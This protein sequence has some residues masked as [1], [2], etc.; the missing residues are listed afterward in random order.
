MLGLWPIHNFSHIPEGRSLY[1]LFLIREH[2]DA[3]R[4]KLLVRPMKSSFCSHASR[5]HSRTGN[6]F[7]SARSHRL[8]GDNEESN[9]HLA[10]KS[11]SLTTTAPFPSGICRLNNEDCCLNAISF[12]S[13]IAMFCEIIIVL[14][15]MFTPWA[16]WAHNTGITPKKCRLELVQHIP[17]IHHGQWSHLWGAIVFQYFAAGLEW[18]H[19]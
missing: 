3:A 4:L 6:W 10:K 15:I 11:W 13:N 8:L 18:L 17:H 2:Y 19:R 9:Y 5:T 1:Y 14:Q 16:L 12:A 7:T